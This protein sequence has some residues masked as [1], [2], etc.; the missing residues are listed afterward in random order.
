MQG[1]A[2]MASDGLRRRLPILIGCFSIFPQPLETLFTYLDQCGVNS[3]NP[4]ELDK[5]N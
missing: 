1:K 3:T 2:W 4:I 5:K